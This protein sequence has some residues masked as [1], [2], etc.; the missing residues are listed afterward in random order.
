MAIGG[1]GV[2]WLAN[3]AQQPQVDIRLRGGW[4]SATARMVARDDLPADLRDGYRDSIGLFCFGE[5]LMWRP[6]RPSRDGIRD[7]HS[8]WL[9]TGTAVLLTMDS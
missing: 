7:L 9:D 5:Y 8:H 2:G 3:L 4:R 6:G 1:R